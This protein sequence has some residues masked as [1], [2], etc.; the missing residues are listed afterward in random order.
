MRMLAGSILVSEISGEL[1]IVSGGSY[2][3]V[4]GSNVELL[5]G[6][7]KMSMVVSA[8]LIGV[9][10]LESKVGM[11]DISGGSEGMTGGSVS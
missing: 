4:I 7:S 10:S 1:S 5:R 8:K 9:S 6:G 3:T 2:E 11:L